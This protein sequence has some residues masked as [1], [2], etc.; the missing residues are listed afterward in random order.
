MA[1]KKQNNLH[2][3]AWLMWLVGERRKSHGLLN[4]SEAENNKFKYDFV[5]R[6][7]GTYEPESVLNRVHAPP[8][9]PGQKPKVSNSFFNLETHKLS[10]LV[11]EVRFYKVEQTDLLP[12]Y[13]P[14][15]SD[16]SP[17]ENSSANISG[18]AGGNSTIKSFNVTLKGTDPFTARK[19]LTARLVISVDSLSNIFLKTPGYARLADLFTI[20]V[21]S[22]KMHVNTGASIKA[23]QVSRPVEIAATI[24]YSLRDPD[25]VFTEGEIREVENNSMSLRMNVSNHTINVAKDGTA[26]I[27]IDYIARIGTL[28]EQRASF[29]VTNTVSDIVKESQIKALEEDTQS[30]DITHSAESKEKKARLEREAAARKKVSDKMLELRKITEVL[31]KKGRIFSETTDPVSLK[32]Y[33]KGNKPEGGADE[34]TPESTA[35]TQ[36]LSLAPKGTPEKASDVNKAKE[37][38]AAELQ[39]IDSPN[40]TFHYILFGDLIEQFCKT[41]LDAM[42]KAKSAIDDLDVVDSEKTKRKKVIQDNMDSL[43]SLKIML[44]NVKLVYPKSLSRPHLINLADIPISTEIYQK[45]VF[46]EIINTKGQVYSI[47]DFLTNCVSVIL[48]QAFGGF[49]IKAPNVLKNSGQVFASTT[50]SGA[51]IRPALGSAGV[52]VDQI[53]GPNHSSFLSGDTEDEYFLIYPE[54]E[55]ET[56]S[57]RSGNEKNDFEDNIYHFHLGKDKGIIKNISF[58]RLTVPYRQESLMTNQ[59]GLYDEL[60]MPYNAKIDMF[61]NTLFFPGSQV[62]IDPFSIGFGDPRDSSSFAA[63]LGIGGY[64][65]VIDVTISYSSAGTLSTNLNC[66]FSSW[67]EQ[68]RLGT[69]PGSISEAGSVGDSSSIGDETSDDATDNAGPVYESSD[70]DGLT[71]DGIREGET[72]AGERTLEAELR[73]PAGELI[74]A[75]VQHTDIRV[76]EGG[77]TS[78]DAPMSVAPGD[79]EDQ[80][81]ELTEFSGTDGSVV[82][83]GLPPVDTGPLPEREARRPLVRNPDVMYSDDD[84]DDD[85]DSDDNVASEPPSGNG[86]GGY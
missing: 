32:K 5:R 67:P 10:L 40:R 65:V 14:I 13:F 37:I 39:N 17:L 12:F 9:S 77:M 66:S 7:T 23:G 4:K 58:Q 63:D 76:P 31:E 28:E 27:T 38:A 86:G 85:D 33:Q 44:P 11:P 1:T 59:V 25:G 57:R 51:E 68:G 19:F 69:N 54:P 70:L 26:N 79:S 29:S 24:G 43:G 73:D 62:Y 46:N 36:P 78:V 34:S 41:R 50:F 83:R 20:S 56:P 35:A 30:E 80:N 53:Q 8:R 48:P 52:D 55:P 42:T 22:G 6:I 74:D 21:P 71:V 18:Y 60:R 47:T 84:D 64:Y 75:I 45:Y 81:T 49:E 72:P 3:Q 16:Y 2:P 15:V 61:G 82:I